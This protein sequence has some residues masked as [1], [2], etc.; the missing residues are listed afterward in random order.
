MK[1]LLASSLIAAAVGFSSFAQAEHT[2]SLGYAQ[3]KVKDF[4]D[5]KGVNAKYL[6]ETDSALGIIGSLTYMQGSESINENSSFASYSDKHDLK[7]YS[8]AAGP[9][10][11]INQFINI[12]GLVGVAHTSFKDIE[13]WSHTDSGRF[14]GSRDRSASSTN[15]MYGAGLQINPIENIAIDIGYEGSK[16]KLFEKNYSVNGFNVGIGYRF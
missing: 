13:E 11:R 8:L 9:T 12:Y 15:L 5:I 7:Y 3:S 6:Y 14:T 10:Y 2:I 1:K 4:K 16:A